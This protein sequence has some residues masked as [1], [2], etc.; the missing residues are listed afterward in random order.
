M[1][2]TARAAVAAAEQI[3]AAERLA[4]VSLVRSGRVY[5]LGNDLARDMPKGPD[6]T[7][8]GFRLTPYHVP[9]ALYRRDDPPAFDFSVETVQGALHL[10]THIDAPAHIATRG[11]HF[12]G[13]EVADAYDDFGWKENGIERTPPIVGRGVLLDVPR[14]RGADKL[15]DLYEITRDDLEACLADH[16]VE[17]RAGD[18][19]LVRTGKQLDYHGDG[20]AYFDA[21][22]GV[23]RDAGIWLYEQGM[24]VLGTDTTA[25]EPCPFPDLE[26]TTH[27][28]LL[29]DRGVN[30]IEILNLEELAADRVHEF[31]FVCLPLKIRGATGS[32]V[33]PVAIV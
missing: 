30:L 17:L 10:S 22:P 2:E 13:V 23:G 18:A 20:R 14:V 16:G 25:T 3:G 28:A 26:R 12:G 29:T 27:V 1:A 31:L 24:A 32:W 15:P 11:R 6:E 9:Q 21:Q 5:D 19:V 33:R 4:A 7:F 8:G